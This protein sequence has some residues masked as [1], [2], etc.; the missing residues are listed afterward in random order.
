MKNYVGNPTPGY[1][2]KANPQPSDKPCNYVNTK[3]GTLPTQVLLNADNTDYTG[4][5]RKGHIL[6]T[7]R[8]Y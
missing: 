8:N 6:A 1:P 3:P 4:A 5:I 7:A 2:D